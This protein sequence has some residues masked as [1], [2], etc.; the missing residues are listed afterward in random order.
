VAVLN[1]FVKIQYNLKMLSKAFLTSYKQSAAFLPAASR[2]F[3][4]LNDAP[5][6]VVVTGA[7]GQ[8]SYSVLF[9]I[10]R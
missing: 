3:A 7:A 8:I 1:L 6:R 5:K 4:S 2:S 9:R 10:A